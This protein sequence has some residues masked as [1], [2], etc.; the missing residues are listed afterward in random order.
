MAAD[1]EQLISL[2][3]AECP[4]DV[5]ESLEAQHFVDSMHEDTQHAT[6]QL[7]EKDLKPALAYSMNYEAAKTVSSVPDMS[8]R[9]KYMMIPAGNVMTNLNHS[10]ICWKNY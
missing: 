8:D 2:A 7:D 9:L 1:M 4:L 10:A 6:R 5:R 3:Y